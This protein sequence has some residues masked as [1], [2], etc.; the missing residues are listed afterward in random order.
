VEAAWSAGLVLRE[1]FGRPASGISSKSGAL[2]LVS[3]A[4]RA[5][6]AA[7]A[8]VLRRRR[9]ADGLLG[10]EQTA[11]RPGS[12]GLRWVV[13]P[14]DGTTNFLS[15]I[16]LWSVSVACEDE[17]GTSAGAVVDPLRG[18]VFAAARG[19][20]ARMPDPGG[21]RRPARRLAEAVVAGGIACATDAEVKRAAKLDKRLF[22]RSGQRRALGSAAL[23]LAWTAVGRLDVCFHE[24]RLQPWDVDAGLLICAGAGLRVHRLPPLEL[25]LAPRLLAVPDALAAEVLA[26]IGPGAGERRRAAQRAP[27][28]PQSVAEELRRRLS[29]ES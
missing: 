9:P 15:G 23:E 25:E 8:D 11:D 6:E 27:L 10:E 14:L 17:A 7:I 19:A 16:P 5:A 4:D 24:Q 21:A 20:R 28:H 3:D 18:E 26:A 22:G 2:D 1:R 29:D 13:D 12:S